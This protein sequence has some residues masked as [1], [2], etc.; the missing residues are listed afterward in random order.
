M[1]WRDVFDGNK[2]VNREVGSTSIFQINDFLYNNTDYGYFTFNGV[3]FSVHIPSQMTN[4]EVE[5]GYRVGMKVSE[6]Q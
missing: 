5:R 3:V 6:L 1:N 4:E 2:F